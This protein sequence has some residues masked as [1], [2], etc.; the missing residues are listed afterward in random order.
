MVGEWL[1]VGFIITIMVPV[2]SISKIAA[3]G[4]LLYRCKQFPIKQSV[5]ESILL[6]IVFFIAIWLLFSLAGLL[7]YSG[8]YW[9]T[10]LVQNIGMV[11]VPYKHATLPRVGLG[12]LE[13]WL[14]NSGTTA[15]F[16]RWR[17]V[18]PGWGVGKTAVVIHGGSTLLL[19]LI[20]LLALWFFSVIYS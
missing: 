20:H 19:G 1:V 14:L 13:L 9:V 7:E 11:A 5:Q 6:F 2:M 16:W 18:E 3:E 10:F 17:G 4:Y 8:V 15:V 12:L